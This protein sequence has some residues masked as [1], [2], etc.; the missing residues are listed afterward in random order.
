MFC[1]GDELEENHKAIEQAQLE[2]ARQHIEEAKRQAEYDRK[3]KGDLA[4]EEDEK[5][6]GAEKKE[7]PAAEKKEEAPAAEA[8]AAAK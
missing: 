1:S 6:E 3:M 4:E 8:E 5:K 7:E 2:A